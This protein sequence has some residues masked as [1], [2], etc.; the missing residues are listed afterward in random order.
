KSVICYDFTYLHCDDGGKPAHYGNSDYQ[1]LLGLPN[2]LLPCSLSIMDAVYSTAI[3]PKLIVD[4]LHDKN[5][6]SFTA[7]MVQLFVS[8]AD[9]RYVAICKPLHFLTIMNRQVCILLLVVAWAG[10]C[11]HSFLQILFV[12]N[13]LFCGPDVIDDFMCDMYLLLG[14]A[15]TDTYFFGVTVVASG[16][17]SCIVVFILLLASHGIILNS[18]RAHS[19]EGRYKALSTCSS[20]IMVLV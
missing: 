12:Y 17:V 6:I 10:G 7:C 14:L 20:H 11:V 8:M 5:T 13:L 9:D 1:S 15:C 19:Q 18:L 2:V 16:G 4:L 3:S